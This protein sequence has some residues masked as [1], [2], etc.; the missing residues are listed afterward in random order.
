MAAVVCICLSISKNHYRYLKYQNKNRFRIF[1]FLWKKKVRLEFRKNTQRCYCFTRIAI[2]IIYLNF[3]TYLWQLREAM[4][5]WNRT[6][7]VEGTCWWNSSWWVMY[8]FDEGTD[9]TSQSE[10]Q[11]E[12]T[13]YFKIKL[14]W[15]NYCKAFF[16][17]RC[18]RSWKSMS[19]PSV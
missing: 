14:Q 11:I 16:I 3:V 7:I 6:P 8:P 18:F 4:L 2:C 13:F 10:K 1:F 9:C 12:K 17:L 19:F 5:V 15:F